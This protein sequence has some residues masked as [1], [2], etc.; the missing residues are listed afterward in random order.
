M[1]NKHSLGIDFLKYNVRNN[2]TRITCKW[3]ARNNEIFC[4]SDYTIL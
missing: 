2:L 1:L 4:I 3:G